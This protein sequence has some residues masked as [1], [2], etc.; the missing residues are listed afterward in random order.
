MTEH[1]FS[2]MINCISS[3]QQIEAEIYEEVNTFF[4]NA[5]RKAQLKIMLDE[6]NFLRVRSTEKYSQKS[7][8]KFCKK[9]NLFLAWERTEDMVDYRNIEEAEVV[10]Y[11][12][13]FGPGDA[14]EGN[15][16]TD[17]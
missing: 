13:G 9:F 11:E 5:N 3:L 15:G 4:E 8:K 2:D 16:S 7:L 14:D 12:Y 10:V 17:S 1:L 6:F